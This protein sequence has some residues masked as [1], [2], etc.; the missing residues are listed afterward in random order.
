MDFRDLDCFVN[1]A[2]QLNI[3]RAAEIL[4]VTQPALSETISHL[5]ERIGYALFTRQKR[6]LALTEAGTVFFE[7]AR[8]ILD[9][10]K[11][12]DEEIQNITGGI[13]GRIRLGISY[14]YSAAL[15]P[16][17][18]SQFRALYPD[19]EINVNTQTSAVLER[20]LLDDALDVVIMVHDKAHEDILSKVLFYEQILLAISPQNPIVAKAVADKNS[21]YPFIP[22]EALH[23]QQF[24]LSPE[25]TRL[26]QS[27]ELFFQAEHIHYKTTVI[28]AS[29]ETANRLAALGSGIAFL[30]ATYVESVDTPPLP[31]YFTAAKSLANWKVTIAWRKQRATSSL[32]QHFV[33]V[34]EESI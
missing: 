22:S 31:R 25:L 19:V 4:H 26:R 11:E 6:G 23:N 17:G 21:D 16:A 28:T 9:A 2:K 3:S 24:I 33:E 32:I 10:K 20:L 14:S 12:L 27:A 5:E 7:K 29:I 1:T 8:K 18:L 15:L 30:P 34:F 13:S